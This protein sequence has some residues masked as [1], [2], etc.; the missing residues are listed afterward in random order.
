MNDVRLG[1]ARPPE[2]GTGAGA[3]HSKSIL[4]GEHAVVYG[5]PALAIPVD[6]LVARAWARPRDGGIHLD[7]ELYT[8]AECHLEPAVGPVHAAI[9]AAL[10]AVGLEGTGVSV[11]VESSIPFARGLGSSAAV[12]AA[13]GRAI[14]AMAGRTL[15]A[16]ELNSVIQAAETVAHGKPSGLDARTVVADAPLRFERGA[17][18]PVR[19]AGE[20]HFVIADTGITGNT[21]H[22]VATVREQHDAD[23]TR[24]DEAI[25]ALSALV[26]GAVE[27]FGAHDLRALGARMSAAHSELRGLRV[28]TEELDAL[29]AEA[30][31]AGALGAKLTGSG[32]GGCVLALAGSATEAEDIRARLGAAGAVETWHTKVDP[33]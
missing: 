21:A 28:S 33:T 14:G 20:V 13:I 18:A 26:E 3:A 25:A 16:E 12:G 23:P 19:V 11:R 1:A 2:A 29:V 5:A 6:S 15:G 10:A 9:T 32:L 31:S 27:D 4:L 24:V 8:G 17:V 7:S 30:L 22:A